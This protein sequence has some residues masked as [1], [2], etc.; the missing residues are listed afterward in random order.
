MYRTMLLVAIAVLLQSLAPGRN[1]A[2]AQTPYPSMAAVEQYLISDENS[3]IELARSAAPASISGNAEVLI[4]RRD[5][6]TTAAKGTNGFVC[7][8]ERL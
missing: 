4:L 2:A 8:V 3:E 6:Y 7:I 1:T 5:G